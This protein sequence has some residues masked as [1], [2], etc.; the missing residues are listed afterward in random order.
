[1][2]QQGGFNL[3]SYLETLRRMVLAPAD[4]LG[5]IPEST[6]VRKPLGFLLLA[7]LVHAVL[8]LALLPPRPLL[9]AVILFLNAVLMPLIAAVI[10]YA[11]MA[12]MGKKSPLSKVLAV[13]FYAA[14][15]T[16][17]LS[18]I[19]LAVWLMEPWKWVLI[20]IG[21][22]RGCG[23]RRL[24]AAVVIIVSIVS[25]MLLFSLLSPLVVRFRG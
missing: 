12:A 17:I 15:T 22:V 13:Y 21:M 11:L 25:I 23:L 1:M 7:S 4:F 5:G 18:W 14:G 3:S 6:G 20:G 8:S 16:H 24:Q 19:P 2:E 9:T 10:G